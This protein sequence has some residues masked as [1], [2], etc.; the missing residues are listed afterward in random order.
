MVAVLVAASSGLYLFMGTVLLDEL[1]TGLRARAAVLAGDLDQPGFRLYAPPPALLELTEQ[2]T[3]VLATDG[4][5][6]DTSPGLTGTVVSAREAATITAPVFLQRRVAGVTG[7]AR[8]LAL[9]A[10]RN[11]AL[12]VLV[13]GASMSDRSDAL[14]LILLF[15]LTGGPVGVLFA[16]GVGWALAG[17]ALRPVERMRRQAAAITIS[18]LD[19][20]LSVP[21]TRDEFGRLARTLN[22]MLCRLDASVAAERRFL[23]NASHE[24]RTPLTV[25]KTE[26]DLALSRPR[27]ADE[28]MTALRSVAEETNRLV[29][30]ADD[31]LF[32]ARTHGKLPILR[33]PVAIAELLESSARLFRTRARAAH[34]AIDVQAPDA[35]VN[36]DAARVRQAVDNLVD[37]ALRHAPPHSTVTVAAKVDN[38]TVSIE[39][40]D[41]GP[42]IP[43]AFRETVFDPYVRIPTDESDAGCGLGLAIVAAVAAG[44]GGSATVDPAIINGAGV[45]LTLPTTAGDRQQNAR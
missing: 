23:D 37:N 35:M 14:R 1:D 11:A 17:A 20:R 19:R 26:I 2:F 6:L 27:T 7:Q 28:L 41:A 42:G 25:L 15:V 12:V 18:G 43:A 8:I 36:V 4:T 30:M 33:A 24:L 40:T 31:L 21:A 38:H 16:S 45:L 10:R 32:L 13:V 5:V 22:D 29:R 39:V 34:V 44:H 9:P 3:Q